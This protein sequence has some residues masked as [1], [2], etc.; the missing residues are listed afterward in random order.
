MSSV[1]NQQL[2]PAGVGGTATPAA[3]Q[4]GGR[5]RRSGKKRTGKKR[6]GKKRSGKKRSGKKRSGKKH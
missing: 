3:P 6:T 2:G 1:D 4:A 5:K